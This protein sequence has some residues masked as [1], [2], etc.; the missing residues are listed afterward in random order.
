MSEE[1]AVE[2]VFVPMAFPTHT[3]VQR[4]AV[5][6]EERLAEAL[7]T[8]GTIVSLVG[9][10]KSGKTVLVEKVVG[11]ENLVV[12]N[13]ANIASS[14]DV[15]DQVLDALGMPRTEE[16]ADGSQRAFG[17]G[18]GPVKG[19]KSASS[20]K[21]RAFGRRGWSQVATHGDVDVL[22][23][24]FHYVPVELQQSVA[25]SL[26]EAAQLGIRVCV[27]AVRHRGDDLV[28]AN[29]D[30]RGRVSPLDQEYWDA[31]DLKEIALKGFAALNLIVDDV[32]LDRFAVEAAGSPQLMQLICLTACRFAGVSSRFA[33]KQRT[34][35]L[36]ASD[37]DEILRRASAMADH[38]T[39]VN[40]L[41]AG[42]KIR[43]KPRKVY[44]FADGS[45]GDVY[46]CVLKVIAADPPRLSFPYAELVSRATTICEGGL[47]P[48]S[49]V[50][51][52]CRHMSSLAAASSD[53]AVDWDDTKQV[54]D[55]PDPYLLFF[56]RWSNTIS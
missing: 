18:W 5:G 41:D 32:V 1:V 2:D 45:S 28:R 15:A 55:V 38:T 8:R 50:V 53:R 17:A 26:K 9:P 44:D 12:I 43:G 25:H 4:A 24:D 48:G 29:P 46:R 51:E 56:L 19:E 16:Q 10:S 30:L 23:D 3:Y 33:V 7:R 39:L 49:S 31:P 34:A 37:V 52:T 11:H 42:P 36:S 21:V 47:P 13:G 20:Q 22:I 54:L 27:A 6:L 35:N 40:V 14:S